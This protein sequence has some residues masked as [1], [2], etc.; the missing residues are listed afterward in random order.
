M[1]R[2]LNVKLV[3]SVVGGLLVFSVGVHF[4]HGYQVE[5][6]A[7]RLLERADQA[8]AAK[9]DAKA[10]IYYDQYL[11]LV[12]NDVDTMQ[13]Y[14][15]LLDRRPDDADPVDL[16]V[17]M[18]KVLRVKSD[19]HELRFRLV[20]NLLWLDRTA[21]A[22]VNLKKLQTTWPDKAIILHMTGWCQEALHEYPQAARSFEEAIRIN[23]KQIRSYALLADLLRD[24]L[25]QPEEGHKVMDQLV[26]ANAESYEAYL[27]RAHF[28]R[29]VDEKGAESDRQTAYRLAP[30]QPEV[31]LAVADAARAKG[32]W[33]E[34]VKLLQEGVKRFP[35]ETD[36]YKRIADV[37][38]LTA[39]N[40]EA[41]DHL[42]TGLAQA[43]RSNELSVLLIDLLIDEK[44]HQEARTRIGDLIKAGMRPALPSYLNARLAIADKQWSEAIKLLLSARH[45]LGAGSE[46]SS[47]VQVLLG[48]SYRQLGDHEQELQA[49]RQA[50]QDEPNWTVANV[51]LAAALLNNGRLEEAGQALEPL[52]A[53]KDLP[54]EYWLLLSRALIYRQMRLPEAERRWDAVEE[55]L[56]KADPKSVE[57]AAVRAEMRMAH[58][59]FVA[60]KAVLEKAR[61]DHPADVSLTCALADLAA[62][63]SQ[64]DEAEK[65]LNQADDSIEVRLAKC[66]LWSGRAN[67][68]DRAKLA[69]LGE[70]RDTNFTPEQRARLGRELADAWQRLGDG[71]RAES[72]WREVARLV[73]KDLRS[74]SALFDMALQKNQMSSA[75]LWLDEMRAIEGEQGRL[76]RYGEAALLV[77]DARGRR[78]Q[79]DEARKKLLELEQLHKNWSRVTLLSATISELEGNQPQAIQ[80]YT[81]ALEL[82]ETQPRVLMNLLNLLI[83]RREFSKA[84]TELTKYEQKLP[85]T[86][87][88]ARIGAEIAMGMRD[89]QYAR[90][91]M[92]RAEQ[93]VPL[94]VR[95]YRDALWLARIYQAAGET[96]KAEAMLRDSLRE[97]GHTPD[98]WIAWMEHLQQTKQREQAL[99]ELERLKKELPQSRQPLTIVRCYEALHLV[100]EAGKAY[101]DA[102]RTAPEDFILLAY[103][104]DFYRRGDQNAE[105]VKLYERLLDPTLAAPAEYTMPARRRLAI[106]LG[107]H[108]PTKA[109][110][111]LDD[112]KT[113]RGDTIADQRIR[114]FLEQS[115]RK[116]QDSLTQQPPTPDERLLLARLLE[117]AGHLN[118]ARSQL[119]E[120]VDENPAMAQYLVRYARLL[121]RMSEREDAERA[122]ARLEALEPGS[123]RTREVRMALTRAPQN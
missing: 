87:E 12:P 7:Y 6:N 52:R 91:A 57:T 35:K 18:E 112:N 8:V 89:G 84:E 28:R 43:P 88:L 63:Q 25:T 67:A 41:I 68:A 115:L 44:Q 72:L 94:P 107:S 121:I 50:V 70:L 79:L 38:M 122:I 90:L 1:R 110:A 73:P 114:L 40:S 34:A 26:Q 3:A 36:F 47:R 75:R 39:K 102:L 99:Q 37:K 92:K 104:A 42:K 113:N 23:P 98:T 55:A 59:D 93:A 19:Q 27:L 95:D 111:L 2:K 83:Q 56:G 108:N 5:R 116:F 71:A 32:N 4:L 65:I 11:A 33:T 62:R 103:A 54:T 29:Q 24:R 101:Q 46:W 20:H 51:G 117:S 97:A 16:V 82:G 80:E 30:D 9:E 45:N 61:L 21:E 64:F 15:E 77:Q 22:L 123:E 58:G 53:A 74:R 85:L 60:A 31:I 119:S 13:K 96:A 120:L 14:A 106:L 10:L 69:R 81:R 48:L 100:A 49:F 109:L 17:K 86:Q 78:S 105:A 118:D 76:W 66:R